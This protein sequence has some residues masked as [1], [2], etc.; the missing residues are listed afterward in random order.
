MFGIS[1]SGFLVFIAG[2]L[3]IFNAGVFLYFHFFG[4][5]DELKESKN[6]LRKKR[7]SNNFEEM[8]KEVSYNQSVIS[9]SDDDSDKKK[10][11]SDTDKQLLDLLYSND[12]SDER[13]VK[14]KTPSDDNENST[15]S[16]APEE[17]NQ[18]STVDDNLS[19]EVVSSSVFPQSSND[20]DEN[21]VNPETLG[22]NDF[23]PDS[24]IDTIDMN[25]YT[26]AGYLPEEFDDDD[27][28]PVDDN[29]SL[30]DEVNR[31]KEDFV[32]NVDSC[33]TNVDSEIGSPIPVK[34]IDF[35]NVIVSS[36]IQFKD[37]SMDSLSSKSNDPSDFDYSR[38]N[39]LIEPNDDE[40]DFDEPII[41]EPSVVEQ[42]F[43]SNEPTEPRLNE[44]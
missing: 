34:K 43:D 13:E 1:T 2:A 11:L 33:P 31:L 30:K 28:I 25:P 12:S 17:Q 6:E 44:M 3:V 35:S 32:V 18:I 16:D 27:G 22:D 24:I 9:T 10:D 40:P 39:N 15:E 7:G 21:I 14:Y 41:D 38:V 8:S 36:D 42:D 19:Q 4:S 5:S 29:F 23:Y 26:M 37:N 20:F